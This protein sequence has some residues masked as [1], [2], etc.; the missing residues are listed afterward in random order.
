MVEIIKIIVTSFKRYHASTA[1][2]SAP[3]IAA[4]H[5]QQPTLCQ[6]LLDTPGQVRVSLLWGHCSFLLGP[7]AHNVLF[8][9]TK[10]LF[11]QSWVCSGSTMVELMAMASKRAYATH[12]STAP[13]ALA[14]AAD[15]HW[16]ISPQETLK[17]N[18]VTVSEESLGPG[19]S[20][21]Q[22]NCLFM[23]SS[24]QPHGL[25]HA[26]PPC[27]S[28][29]PGVYSNSCQL[30]W[31]CHPTISSSVIPF[32]SCLQSFLASGSFQMSQFFASSG[33]SIGV[34]ASTSQFKSINSSVLSFLYFFFQVFLIF[35]LYIF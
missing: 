31:W 5:R 22:F 1:A 20:S 6:R 4:G 16:P 18:Y 21:V 29:T 19:Q 35:I 15:H 7:G 8:I 17:H 26:M 23:S 13:R 25:Q 2:F 34:S 3:N 9:T 14:P 33:Q 30:S 11:P 32:S 10:S 12:R 28:P 27:P 24:L